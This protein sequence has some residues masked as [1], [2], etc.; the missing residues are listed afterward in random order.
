MASAGSGDDKGT[1]SALAMFAMAQDGIRAVDEPFR[2]ESKR[3]NAELRERRGAVLEFMLRN[4]LEEVEDDESGAV[5]SITRGKSFACAGGADVATAGKRAVEEAAP[6]EGGGDEDRDVTD[7]AFVTFLRRRVNSQRKKE[8]LPPLG[9]AKRRPTDGGGGGSG[10]AARASKRG[11]SGSKAKKKPRRRQSEDPAKAAQ[12]T[13]KR[14][15][16]EEAA[17]RLAAAYETKDK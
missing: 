16:I 2:A 15:R 6:G 7:E 13:A 8:G 17:T 10:G 4:G 9:R 14:R 12:R 1:A 5:L 3:L 11:S